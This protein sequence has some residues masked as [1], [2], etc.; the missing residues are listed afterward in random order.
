M[1]LEKTLYTAEL[2][3]ICKEIFLSNCPTYFAEFELKEFTEWLDKKDRAA[4]YIY[5]LNSEVVACSGIYVAHHEKEAGMAWGMVLNEKH[6]SGIGTE[7]TKLRILEIQKI[8]PTYAI[9][10]KTSQHTFEF[11]EKMGFKVTRIDKDGFEKGMDR[12]WMTYKD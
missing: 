5:I 4:Y 8:Y 10:L 1:K 2:K 6:G 12:Y 3:N 7:M 9:R 11:Y